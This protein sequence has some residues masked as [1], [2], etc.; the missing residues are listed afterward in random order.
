MSKINHIM[1]WSPSLVNIATNKAVF[2][3]AL[4]LKKFDKNQTYKCSLLNFFGEFD[5]IKETAIQNRINII[6]F[7]SNKFTKFLPR[8]G[9]F[10][11]RI[12]F[13]FMFFRFDWVTF[14]R[15][16]LKNMDAPKLFPKRQ[17]HSWSWHSIKDPDDAVSSLRL[18]TRGVP[19]DG[20]YP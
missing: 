1:Y 2:N 20:D 5:K 11:S 18:V 16:P 12:S 3:S 17:R 10:K 13:M 15:T 4:S 6:N 8:H 19:T 9:K 14:P 7:F